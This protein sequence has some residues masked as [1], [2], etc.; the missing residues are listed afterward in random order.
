MSNTSAKFD[1]ISL[2]FFLIA[3]LGG[4]F[5]YWQGF[6]KGQKN[7]LEKVFSAPTFEVDDVAGVRHYHLRDGTPV[8]FEVKYGKEWAGI[9]SPFILVKDKWYNVPSEEFVRRLVLVC[10]NVEELNYLL[11]RMK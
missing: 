9:G 5:L 1:W 11:R 10:D 3:I 4:F 2:Q 7:M 8:N 6:I